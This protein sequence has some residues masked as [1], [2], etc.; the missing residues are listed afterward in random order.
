MDGLT[1][2]LGRGEPVEIVELDKS[3]NVSRTWNHTVDNHVVAKSK[4]SIPLIPSLREAFM[5]VGYPHSV[6]SDYLNYQFFDSLQAFFST[7]T[8]LLANRAL[9]QGLGVGDANSSATFAMLLTVLKDA[10]SR[11]ATIVFAHQFGL[12]IEP[13][14]KRFRFLADLFND[15]AFFLELYS[16]YFGPYGKILALTSGETLRA[17]CGVAAGASKAA[18]SVHF[19]KHD[20]LSELNAK[21][22][23]QETAVGLIGLLVGTIVVKYVEE[24]HNVLFLMTVL[25]FAHLWMNY[26]GVRAV[27][28]DNLNQQRATILF[29]EY[30]KTGNVLSPEEVAHRENI[31][32]WRPVV[33]NQH[34]Q[35]IA[36][37]EMAK[38][39][40]DAMGA[41]APNSNVVIIDGARNSLFVWYHSK[42]SYTP[43]KIMLWQDASAIHAIS[44]WFMAMEMAWLLEKSQGYTDKLDKI[45]RVK[46]TVDGYE[47]KYDKRE[48]WDEMLAKGWNIESQAFETGAPVRLLAQ[49]EGKKDQ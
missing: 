5:P 26:L 15:T 46:E 30:L 10:M 28:M 25:V 8:S 47:Q 16:P 4:P 21:E 32:L 1:Q 31:L 24:H 19:A 41:K 40:W 7:I 17:L 49:L 9:L 3:G 27:C 23:S 42:R 6:S 2:L 48:L 33:R 35:K 22:A 44:A 11:I 12:R 38:S 37:I 18:L 29:E 34:G 14:A 13:D 45:F 20:N 39:Y 43:I 36:R